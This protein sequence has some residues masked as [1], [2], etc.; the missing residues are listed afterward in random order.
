MGEKIK[1]ISETTIRNGKVYIELNESQNTLSSYDIH[2]EAPMF[3]FAMNDSEFMRLTC[4][5]IEARKKLMY[6]KKIGK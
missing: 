2:I 3:R 5:V 4:A 1:N 6:T